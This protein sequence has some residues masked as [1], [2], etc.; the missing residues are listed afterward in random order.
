MLIQRSQPNGLA[1]DLARL[2]SQMN[3]GHDDQDASLA[4]IIRGETARYELFTGRT[5]LPT[6]F[7]MQAA[8]WSSPLHLPVVPFR[9]VTGVFYLDQDG[10][11]QEAD[12][13]SFYTI[14]T[15]SGVDVC[16]TDGFRWPTLA[17]RSDAVRVR[18]MAGH[19]DSYAEPP[20]AALIPRHMIDEVMISLMV[21]RIFDEGQPI[22]DQEMRESM[23]HRRILR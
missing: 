21:A 18:F 12:S 20:A 1:L 17:A 16:A 3:V 15:V 4:Q 22:T 13:A 19:D 14:E 8:G 6:A 5:M 10:V 9:E 23:S 7:E 2:K 11:E